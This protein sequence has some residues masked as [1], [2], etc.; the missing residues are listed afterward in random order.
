MADYCDVG[1]VTQ[2]KLPVQVRMW[3]LKALKLLISQRLSAAVDD[4]LGHVYH[5]IRTLQE[6]E[7][8]QLGA[9]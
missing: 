7:M 2:Q 3:S 4:I 5:T 9:P 1:N 6:E 8:E